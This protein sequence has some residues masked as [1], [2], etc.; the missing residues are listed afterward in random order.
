V[1]DEPYRE[2]LTMTLLLEQPGGGSVWLVSEP[3]IGCVYS[4]EIDDA[5]GEVLR[6]GLTGLR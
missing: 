5:T 2:R 4:V 3:A 6:A 1:A